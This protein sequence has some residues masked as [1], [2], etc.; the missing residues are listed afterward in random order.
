MAVTV[1]DALLETDKLGLSTLG[2]VLSHVIA[3]DRLVVQILIDGDEPDLSRLDSLRAT[4]LSGCTVY[5][6]T[7][8]PIHLAREAL[9]GVHDGFT[10]ADQ[11][12]QE[13]AELFR[14][15]DTAGGLQKLA[16]CFTHWQATHDSV[17]KVAR[18]LR[19][20]LQLVRTSSG[21]NVTELIGAFASQLR[22]LKD[23]LEARDYVLCCDVLTYDM[24]TLASDWHEAIAALRRTA[25][26]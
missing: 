2:D 16:G 10:L 1:D 23:A 6:E 19:V 17:G 20:D 26:C 12:R 15:G 24:E 4:S 25:G 5:I 9:A 7:A 13:S 11:L 22:L 14:T 3:D 18:L 21:K 8:R